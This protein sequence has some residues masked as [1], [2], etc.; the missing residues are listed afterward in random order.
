MVRPILFCSIF[1]LLLV[2]GCA[3]KPVPYVIDAEKLA[4]AS[5]AKADKLLKEMVPCK[6][7]QDC[8]LSAENDEDAYVALIE[9][10]EIAKGQIP[11]GGTVESR[12][13]SIENGEMTNEGKKP[14]I[15][16]NFSQLFGE[17]V[18]VVIVS[19]IKHV[20]PMDALR[21]LGYDPDKRIKH[22]RWTDGWYFITDW[23]MHQV[24]VDDT[25]ESTTV[26]VYLETLTH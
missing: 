3:V 11:D 20:S 4:G 17:V 16:L 26:Y 23:H 9:C 24:W 12:V 10:W 2:V 21:R 14:D 7:I 19:F 13:Y 25:G 8:R 18:D 6:M 1:P 15:I 5:P 22:L